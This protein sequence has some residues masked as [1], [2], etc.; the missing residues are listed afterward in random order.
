MQI[1]LPAP[2]EARLTESHAAL[3]L[4]IGLYVAGEVTLGQAAEVAHLNQ[5]QFIHELGNR[6]ITL[7]FGLEYLAEDLIAIREFRELRAAR[8]N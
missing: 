5:T 1:T 4:A 8:T 2:L 3:H 6:Q 7:R